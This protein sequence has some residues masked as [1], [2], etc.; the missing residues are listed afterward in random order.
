VW[1]S[2]D[3]LNLPSSEEGVE[4]GFDDDLV[5]VAITVPAITVPVY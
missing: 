5:G 2:Y 3:T 4:E 1:L